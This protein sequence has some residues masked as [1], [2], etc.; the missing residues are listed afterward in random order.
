MVNCLRLNWPLYENDISQ[1]GGVVSYTGDVR[2]R[3]CR[4]SVERAEICLCGRLF[5]VWMERFKDGTAAVSS[6]NGRGEEL[7]NLYEAVLHREENELYHGYV[8]YRFVKQIWLLL[9]QLILGIICISNVAMAFSGGL[10]THIA[11]SFISIVMI[12]ILGSFYSKI[13]CYTFEV[14]KKE[15]EEDGL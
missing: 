1:L 5:S 6:A 15:I 9:V 8:F 3:S 13:R 12:V 4:S 10:I 7:Y 11:V 14:Y 2:G